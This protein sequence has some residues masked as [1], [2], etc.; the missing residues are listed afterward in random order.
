MSLEPPTYLS[1]LQN[2]IR[3]RPIPWEGAVR[4]GNITDDHLKKIK[5]VDKV[6]KDQ[7]RQTIEQDLAGYT[8]LLAGGAQGKSV[9]DSASRRTDIVQYIL[10]L[11][12]D[13]I[14]DVPSLANSLISH[15]EPYKPFLPFL[16]HSTNAED[17]IPLLTSTFLTA[18]VSHSLVATSK[19]APRD[20]EALPQLY[21]YLSTLTKNQD[22][23]LQDIGVQ[24][25][26]DLLR[27]SQAREIFWK[28]RQ[29]TLDPLMD[30]LRSAAGGK[31][32]T[33]SQGGS[34]RIEPGLAGGV[35]LQLLYRV[36]LVVWQLAFEGSL[37]GEELQEN[38]EI[39][40][41]YAQ[42]L[43]LSPKEKTTRLLLATLL[44]L[45]SSNRTTLLPV[46]VFVRL[47]ALL[48]NLAGRHLTDPD[49]LEDLT[50][51]SSMLEEYTKTQTTFDQYAA[52][53]QSGH[54]RWSPPHKNPTFWKDNARRIV[55]E[56]NGALPKKLAE[57]LSKSWD[58]DKQVLA[59]ACNDVGSL[60][61]EVPERR[62]QLERLGLKT[63][64]MELMADKDE[65][66][67]WESLH[68]VG[69]W[70]RYTFEG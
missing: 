30:T 6:R 3:A 25:F 9:L 13:L 57:I 56:S 23:G 5:A 47:P 1:S 53:V 51:L 55:E 52:E 28:Q 4:A 26:S 7:R 63:R 18:L 49:L 37:V 50:A 38:Y 2:N 29:E 17:P 60:V 24:G 40:Q 69:E 32:N 48:T 42:L 67:R 10:V 41:L 22:S 65:S 39:I 14:Q 64:V 35:G 11:A 34:S 46:A 27:T 66:V 36:L 15:P 19:P 61:K 70:L 44:N 20:S 16:Q 21:T 54:L 43:R 59:I 68:A 12:S 33:S 8:G 45:C 58:N 31:D 62:T